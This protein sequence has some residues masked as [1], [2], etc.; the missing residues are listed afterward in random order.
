MATA[1]RWSGGDEPYLDLPT[2]NGFGSVT[3]GIYGGS[4][5]AGA[6]KNEDAALVWTS[7]NAA[8]TFAALLDAH[9]SSESADLVLGRVAELQDEVVALLERDELALSKLSARFAQHFG[10][11]DFRRAC[12]AIRGETALLLCAQQGA[13]LWWLSIGDIP[14][15]VFHPEF[16]R[17]GQFALNQR[18]FYEWV[19]QVNTFALPVPCYATGIRQ[20]RP[21]RNRILMATD[22]LLECGSRIFENQRELET[23]FTSCATKEQAVTEAL[24]QVAAEQGRDSATLI[25]WEVDVPETEETMQ[26][27]A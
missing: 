7:E 6:H 16:A 1:F 27:S 14:V 25:A 15:Y 21:G 4:V 17:L 10:D 20:L 9:G 23:L 11:E 19:G 13:Y 18:M 5:A 2:V 24:Q 26:P 12:A 22:G 8:W 3:V